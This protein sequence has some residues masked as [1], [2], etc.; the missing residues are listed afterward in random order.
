MK[1]LQI[2]ATV[3]FFSLE[4][5]TTIS[6]PPGFTQHVYTFKTSKL[7][8]YCRGFKYHTQGI[9]HPISC[10]YLLV[11][12][13]LNDNKIIAFY[14]LSWL[15]QFSRI[16]P[17][18]LE[19]TVR[20]YV[21]YIPKPKTTIQT[22]LSVFIVSARAPIIHPPHLKTMNIINFYW[23]QWSCIWKIHFLP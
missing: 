2:Q 3:E 11:P 23:F 15:L 12:N 22:G 14:C 17:S 8:L 9:L 5:Y 21:I 1:E 16:P 6:S 20:Y 7:S 13:S 18:V 10:L 19:H 4:F